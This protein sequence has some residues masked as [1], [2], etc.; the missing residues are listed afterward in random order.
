MLV[1]NFSFL[2]FPLNSTVILL[3]GAA[4]CRLGATSS[5]SIVFCRLQQCGRDRERRAVHP[6][7]S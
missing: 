5:S 2:I 6:G 1:L 7:D 4:K 3:F